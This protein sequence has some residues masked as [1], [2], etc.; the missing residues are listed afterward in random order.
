MN[1]EFLKA[2]KDVSSVTDKVILKYP[3]TVLKSE[4]GSLLALID[5]TRLNCEEFPDTGIYELSKFNALLSMFDEPQVTREDNNL[6]IEN[7]LNT[8]IFT[9]ADLSILSDFDV[10]STIFDRLDEF[11]SV[12]EFKLEKIQIQNLLKA[13]SIFGITNVNSITLKSQDSNIDMFL[14]SSGRFE[15]NTNTFKVNYPRC[16]EKDFNLKISTENFARIPLKDYNV[17]IKYNADK[18]AYRILLQGDE[19]KI[20]IALLQ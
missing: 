15:N 20:I 14:S 13:A 9:L 5:V 4:D 3:K 17:K 12:A 7:R 10:S 6:K 1:K 16:S 19:F 18:D 8:A 2:L 11:P